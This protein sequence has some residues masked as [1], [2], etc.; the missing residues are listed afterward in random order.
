MLVN[1]HAG[2]LP[3]REPRA[4]WRAILPRAAPC[5]ALQSIGPDRDNCTH[6]VVFDRPGGRAFLPEPISRQANIYTLDDARRLLEA[7]A[8]DVLQADVTRCGVSRDS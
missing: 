2:I 1:L 3:N 4:S 6:A 7:N 5:R 8:V